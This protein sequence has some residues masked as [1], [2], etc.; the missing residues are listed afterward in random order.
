MAVDY[1]HGMVVPFYGFRR[2]NDPT[3]PISDDFCTPTQ[4]LTCAQCNPNNAYGR[5]QYRVSM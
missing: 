4:R 3:L 2:K 1:F 5:K